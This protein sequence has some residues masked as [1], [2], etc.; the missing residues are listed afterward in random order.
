MRKR[1]IAA[2]CAYGV[3]ALMAGLTLDGMFRLVVWLFL[4]LFTVKTVIA[5]KAGWTMRAGREKDPSDN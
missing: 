2:L 3:L 1:F 5:Y 4:A